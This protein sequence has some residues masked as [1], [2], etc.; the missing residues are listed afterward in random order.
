VS[1]LRG[2]YFPPIAYT[3]DSSHINPPCSY[4]DH[5]HHYKRSPKLQQ[6]CT[7][8]VGTYPPQ[9]P[10]QFV[11]PSGHSFTTLGEMQRSGKYHNVFDQCEHNDTVLEVYTE[12]KFGIGQSARLIRTP[13]GNVLWDLVAY[14]DEKT[15]EK[16]SVGT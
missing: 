4:R 3:T 14:L 10:R 5:D 7:D 15:V 11:P 2:I 9:D 1:D 12:P 6:P 13:K 16:V 8:S